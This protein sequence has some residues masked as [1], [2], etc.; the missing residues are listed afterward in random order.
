MVLPAG[1]TV[2]CGEKCPTFH[3]VRGYL[4]KRYGP[5]WATPPPPEARERHFVERFRDA[6]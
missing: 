1:E 4:A 5:D 2:F 3:D 6:P